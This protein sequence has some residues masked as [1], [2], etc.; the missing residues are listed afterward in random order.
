[1]MTYHDV[2]KI[3]RKSVGVYKSYHRQC[4]K[5][6]PFSNEDNTCFHYSEISKTCLPL[7]NWCVHLKKLYPIKKIWANLFWLIWHQVFYSML[8]FDD[9]KY[10]SLTSWRAS[11]P[12]KWG[13]HSDKSTFGRSHEEIDWSLLGWKQSF[14]IISTS[15]VVWIF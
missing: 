1:M 12:K 13:L 14:V 3:L 7:V 2:V 6:N 10:L 8:Y 9:I 11:I 15:S 5:K 4:K